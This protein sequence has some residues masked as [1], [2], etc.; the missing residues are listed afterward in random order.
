MKTKPSNITELCT[1][2]YNTKE[3]ISMK[4]YIYVENQQPYF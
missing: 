1:C 3:Y 2:T 4:V